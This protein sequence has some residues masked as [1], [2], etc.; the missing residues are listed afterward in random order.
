MNA[1]E[2]ATCLEELGG[3]LLDHGGL[4]AVE[5]GG[6]GAGDLLLA[7]RAVEEHGRVGARPRE[8]EGGEGALG[9]GDAVL[10]RAVVE[11]VGGE[12]AEGG[13]HA[14]LN[15]EAHGPHAHHHQPLEQRLR[16]AGARRLLAHH[17]RAQLAVVPHQHLHLLKYVTLIQQKSY[18]I[19]IR[20]KNSVFGMFFFL[21]DHFFFFFE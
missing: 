16:Q 14:V 5:V 19:F 21:L 10:Q 6:A 18:Q 15:L 4:G 11:D 8:V 2:Y 17:H 20:L 12:G 9:G 1:S 7:E 13:V 3:D